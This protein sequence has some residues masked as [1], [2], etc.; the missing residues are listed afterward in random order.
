MPLFVRARLRVAAFLVVA[1]ALAACES[2]LSVQRDNQTWGFFQ[3]SAL[4]ITSGVHAT[5]PTGQFFRGT[6]LTI[7][8]ARV[9]PD[10][11]IEAQLTTQNPLQVTFLDA[12]NAITA[13]FGTRVDTLPRVTSVSRTTYEV[14]TP[15]PYRPGDSVIVR[16]PGVAGGFP[17]SEIRAKTAEAFTFDTLGIRPSPAAVQLRWTPSTDPNSAMLAEFRYSSTGSTT[18]NLVIRCA[19][20]DDGADSVAFRVLQPWL[21]QNAN[22]RSAIYTRLRTN[23]IPVIDGFFE[24]ISTFAVPTPRAQ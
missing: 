16:V 9:K 5:L 18:P 12:G 8:D 22:A 20:V 17:A 7:P 3:Q 10:S 2:T 15:R 23:I 19:F 13:Q 24:V 14:S 6:L 11:C 1:P 4:E 21:G